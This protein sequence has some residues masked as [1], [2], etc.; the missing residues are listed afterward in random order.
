MTS[1]NESARPTF[2]SIQYLRGAAAAGVVTYHVYNNFPVPTGRSFEIGRYGVD[3]F[4][5]IS[6]FIMYTAARSER[7]TRFVSRRLIRVVPLYRLATVVAALLYFWF[8][9]VHPS[10][11]EAVLSLALVPHYSEAHRGEIWPILVPG[12]TLSYEMLFYG[13]FAI[14]LIARRVVAVPIF[15]IAV[16]VT[17]GAIFGPKSAPLIV[18]TSPLLI[19]FLLGILVA[20]AQHRRPAW[21]PAIMLALTAAALGGLAL[22]LER[23]TIFASAA[24]IV[25]GAAWLDQRHHRKPVRALL[26]L[27]DA[28]YSIYLFHIPILFVVD[29][30]IEKSLRAASPATIDAAAV[31]ALAIALVGGV[32]LHFALEKPLLGAVNGWHRRTFSRVKS[33]A[34]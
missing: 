33:V 27:G 9:G 16:L 32:L 12:W 24:A 5:V 25:A 2:W 11:T 13:L 29:R 10:G 19:E 28:S 17:F 22:G 6:G 18:L 14:G 7:V 15:A 4:F 3:V 21:L 31:A 30:S 1:P 8:D 26:T 20:L 34:A 23:V